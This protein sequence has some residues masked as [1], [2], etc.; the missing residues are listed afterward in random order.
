MTITVTLI[1]TLLTAAISLMANSN[2][3]LKRRLLFNAYDIKHG[4]EW[5]RWV[6]HGFVHAD[7]THLA[8]NMWVF[9]MFGQQ[10]EEIFEY[11]FGFMGKFY[12]LTLYLAG[13]IV[14]SIS[15]FIKHQDNPGYN[16]LGASGA[17]ASVMFT[18]ILYLPTQSMGLI[19]LPGIRIPAFLMGI[20]YLWYEYAMG[21][22]AKGRIAHDAH[23]WGAVFGIVF[24]AVL[25]PATFTNF[26]RE[27]SSY[28]MSFAA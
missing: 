20:L 3:E 16:S 1:I 10:V 8:I 5:Y 17:V 12:Y 22:R 2:V 25:S 9:Y 18:F 4:K 13:I 11:E 14:S 7:F 27:V 28:V 23:F 6:S 21:K 24:M 19:F 15:A 26:F